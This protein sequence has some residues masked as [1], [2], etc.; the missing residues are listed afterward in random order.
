MSTRRA[1]HDFEQI[2]QCFEACG[3]RFYCGYA[4]LATWEPFVPSLSVSRLQATDEVLA[5]FPASSLPLELNLTYSTVTDAGMAHLA[6]FPN[7]KMLNLSYAFPDGGVGDKGVAT[8][9]E[10]SESR[11]Y[12]GIGPRREE[13]SKAAKPQEGSQ[14]A[15]LEKANSPDAFWSTLI[16]FNNA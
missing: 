15:N 1:D 14:L 11:I 3:A 16:L 2:R 9:V 5:A 8:V 12:I 10:N 4:R 13:L 6:K 7:L